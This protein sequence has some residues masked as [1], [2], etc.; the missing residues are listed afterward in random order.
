MRLPLCT[1]NAV[2]HSLRDAVQN[3]FVGMR[4]CLRR[5]FTQP[6]GQ[7]VQ[8]VAGRCAESRFI[9]QILLGNGVQHILVVMCMSLCIQ[10]QQWVKALK[11][12]LK[13]DIKFIAREMKIDVSLVR[14]ADVIW[15]QSNAIP[16]RS[17]YSIVNTAR[18]LGKPIRY[19]TNASAAKCA[20][21]IVENDK[22]G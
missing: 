15:I 16:H 6:C 5:D 21:Q 19:F 14:Y 8:R 18:K 11:P 17:Y 20:E 7:T 9:L 2:K 1:C 10:R 13:G 12:L 3:G 22:R 4:M